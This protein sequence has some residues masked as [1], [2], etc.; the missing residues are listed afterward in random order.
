MKTVN[1]YVPELAFKK[2]KSALEEDAPLFKYEEEVFYFILDLFY[3][4]KAYNKQ[5]KY[6]QEGLIRISSKYLRKYITINYANYTRYLIKHKI[7]NCDRIKTAGKAYGYEIHPSVNSKLLCVKITKDKNITKKIIEN[8][9]ERNKHHHRL[10]EHVKL[11]KKHFKNFLNINL[12]EALKWLEEQFASSKISLTQ[13][14]VYFISIHSI[15]DNEK[16]FKLN[17]KNGRIDSNLTNLK[18][19]LRKF[20]TGG[21]FEHI[22]CKNSQP[23]ILN[24]LTSYILSNKD[25]SLYSTISYTIP[26]S[27]GCEIENILHKHLD[28]NAIRYLK[29]FPKVNEKTLQEFQDF[30]T[31]TFEKDFYDFLKNKYENLYGKAISRDEVK[32]TV[33]KVFFSKNTSFRKEKEVFK[34]LYPVI[35]E[36]IC[37]LKQGEH[38]RLALCLQSIESELFIQT[39]CK[40]L[41]DVGIIPLTIHDSIIV[42]EKDKGKALEI[43]AEVYNSIIKQVPQ[44]VCKPL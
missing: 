20:I 44:F 28:S 38:N 18:S 7:I 1:R 3:R 11:M 30:R 13:Y 9:N 40:R 32:E 33:Y 39:I 27:L 35:Y 41:I 21:P 19:D 5:I 36:I 2:I 43:M 23:L 34:K 15:Y 10:P 16:F 14:N 17:D 8:V 24:F 31:A 6:T 4:L 37:K 42:L 29:N 12:S 22:D 25:F 26:P